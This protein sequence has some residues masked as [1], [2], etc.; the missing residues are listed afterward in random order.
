VIVAEAQGVRLF[1]AT[2][3]RNGLLLVAPVLVGMLVAVLVAGGLWYA[4]LAMLLAVPVFVLLHRYP[5]AA[6]LA[7]L[8]IAPFVTVTDSA[9]IRAVFWVVHRLLPV[10]ALVVLAMGSSLGLRRRARVRAGVPEVLMAGYV[11]AT[12]LSI[13]FRSLDPIADVIIFYDRVVLPMIMY[14]LVRYLEPSERDLRRLLPVVVFILITQSVIGVLLWVAPSILPGPWLEHAGRRTTGSFAD[15]NTFGATMAFCGLFLL[16]A[17]LVVRRSH[18]GRS[19]L[20]ISFALAMLMVFLTFGRANW[21]AGALVVLG[22]MIVHRGSVKWIVAI[23]VPA[24]LLLL[25]GGLLDQQIDFAG[26]R[27]HSSQSEEEALSR[28]PV[29]YAAVKMFEL[30]PLTGWGYEAFDRYSRPFQSRV[31]DLVSPEK[32][33]ASHNLYLTLLAEQGIVGLVLFT[34]PAVVWLVRSWRVRRDLPTWG[35]TG[36]KALA[37]LWLAAGS[38]FLVNNFAVMHVTFGLGLWWFILG[39]IASLVDR[40]RRTPYPHGPVRADDRAS[41]TGWT[42]A[43]AGEPT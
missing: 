42:A 30:K 25:G 26:E 33:H 34:S 19:L 18:A 35:L 36:R 32:P 5:V 4:A 37:A 27:L 2:A 16:T 43:E 15:P 9:G 10:A 24:V 13:V 6:L 23:V 7:W 3:G 22:V 28:L 8:I 39:L 40:A 21:L 20:V 14:L 12:L 38:F 11:A 1:P 29:F 41:L 17:G 31:G